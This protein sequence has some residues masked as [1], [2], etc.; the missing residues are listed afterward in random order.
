MNH[1]FNQ[2]ISSWDVTNGKV[3][4]SMFEE[5]T[6]FNQNISKW[7]LTGGT[8]FHWML[9]GASAF[10]QYL[11]PWLK[12]V[13]KFNTSVDW[14]YGAICDANTA[15]FPTTTPSSVPSISQS[16]TENK[17]TGL[18]EESCLNEQDIC[19][20]S[21]KKKILG[22]CQHKKDIYRHDCAQYSSNESC[23]SGFYP[24]MCKWNGEVCSHVC[25]GLSK[26]TCKKKTYVI[27][28]K[29]CTMPKVKNP[30]LGCHLKSKC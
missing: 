15:L 24:G 11:D 1:Q 4:D 27:D 29:I 23:L 7:N 9:K 17:C 20:Y 30:C 2:D 3:F 6:S 14:C 8:S 10:N 19:K 18:D 16:P 26:K 25:D 22:E 21:S 12:W 13:D 5:T 28:L